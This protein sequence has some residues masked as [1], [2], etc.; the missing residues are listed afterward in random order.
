[1]IFNIKIKSEDRDD[2]LDSMRCKIKENDEPEKPEELYGFNDILNVHRNKID[3]INTDIW[4]KVRWYIND[5]DFLVKDPIINRAFYKYWEIVNVFNIFD[6]YNNDN[7]TIFHCAEAPGGF[8][9]GSN[10]YLQLENY[11]PIR[12]EESLIDEEGFTK[13]QKKK[14]RHEKQYKIYTIS[15]NKDLPQYRSYNLPSYN[16]RVINKNICV[17]Y[18]KDNTGDINNLDNLHHIRNLVGQTGSYL[19]T[20]DGGF[21]EGTDFNNKEQLHYY[22]I[23]N[24]I[25]SALCL[26]KSGGHFILKV[27]DIFTTTSVHVLYLLSLV[28]EEV[29]IY[30]PKTS[31]PTNSEKYIICKNMESYDKNKVLLVLR[32]LSE[33][34]KL[35][36]NKYT[37]FTLFDYIPQ[38][39]LDNIQQMNT[40]LLNKQCDSLNKAIELCENDEFIKNYESELESSLDRRRQVF[41][42]WEEM[43]N[44]NCYIPS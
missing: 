4:K 33:K 42:Q 24:E 31:R 26:Q 41:K 8:I 22:L 29:Y 11:K 35:Q 9:Q 7:D 18:G 14:R 34:F 30:K 13:V 16:K 32:Q 40:T 43:Y 28:Y 38:E 39:F 20:A 37:S 27:F 6:K 10:I 19:V 1:M 5:Y 23:L 15:L 12:I 21:D 36:K 25:Y 44:L 2:V 3:K 17:T